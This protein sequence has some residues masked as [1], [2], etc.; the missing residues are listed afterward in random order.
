MERK[1]YLCLPLTIVAFF[2]LGHFKEAQGS[3]EINDGRFDFNLDLDSEEGTIWNL[4]IA[5]F[6]IIVVIIIACSIA[7]CI[8]VFCL[9]RSRNRS[10]QQTGIVYTQGAQVTPV[11]PQS[12]QQPVPPT[13]PYSQELSQ[14]PP[15]YEQQSEAVASPY[16]QQPAYNK[17]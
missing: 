15:P 7:I 12:P 5:M 13:A 17:N 9:I 1:L 8:C 14:F 4:S 11:A 3:N 16:S 6:A 2:M 10:Q